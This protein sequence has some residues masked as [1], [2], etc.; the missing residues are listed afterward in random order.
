MGSK[1][2]QICLSI[3]RFTMSSSRKSALAIFKSLR[4]WFFVEMDLEESVK[5]NL[6]RYEWIW[7][8]NFL[9]SFEENHKWKLVDLEIKFV[10]VCKW[11]DW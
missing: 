2:S 6:N 9:C 3:K 5:I 7:V 11:F 10:R 8:N 1:C 4:V